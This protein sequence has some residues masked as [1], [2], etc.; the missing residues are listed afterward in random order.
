MLDTSLHIFY[1]FVLTCGAGSARII[2]KM[3]RP[4]FQYLHEMV[5]DIKNASIR[6]Y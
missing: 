5:E 4:A 6:N 2:A 1:P 3:S